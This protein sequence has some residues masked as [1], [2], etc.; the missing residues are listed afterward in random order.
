MG[1]RLRTA[2]TLIAREK[3]NADVLLN[4]LAEGVIGASDEGRVAIANPAA[5]WL[6]GA[7]VER[8]V[9]LASVLPDDL[10]R[11]F[12]DVRGD[13]ETQLVVF[14]HGDDMLE[15]SVYSVGRETE[16]RFLIVLRNITEQA[17]LDQARRDFIATASHELK[18]PLFSLSG[19][20]ELIDEGEL[21]ADEQ[22][23]FLT[24]MRQQV[25]RL[26][27][28]SLEPARPLAGRRRYRESR[29]QRHRRD[30]DGAGGRG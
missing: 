23:E 10:V 15:G 13:G 29:V 7:Q 26:T 11:A 30:R 22:R 20:M 9:T 4:D 3:E 8:G 6:L 1:Q 21:N 27:D 19:F 24:L 16:V 18:T 12:D 25:D 28:L 2:F 14:R 17:R 5:G